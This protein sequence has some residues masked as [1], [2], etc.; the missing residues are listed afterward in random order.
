MDPSVTSEEDMLLQEEGIGIAEYQD[1][2]SQSAET[3]IQIAHC[4]HYLSDFLSNEL[5]QVG[6]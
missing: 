1:S 5:D 4:T 6:G 2:H 3:K